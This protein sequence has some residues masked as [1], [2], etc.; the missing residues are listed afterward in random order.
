MEALRRRPV[1]HGGGAGAAGWGAGATGGGGR[2]RRGG[3]RSRRGR[4]E[5]QGYARAEPDPSQ[6]VE[7]GERRDCMET[8]TSEE[9]EEKF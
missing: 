5:L 3:G 2:S 7:K 4:Q 9:W 8:K 6:C 1:G